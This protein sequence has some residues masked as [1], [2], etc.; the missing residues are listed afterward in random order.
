[1]PCV[2]PLPSLV[3]LAL[4]VWVS[5]GV[6]AEEPPTQAEADPASE[7]DPPN[8]TRV[9]G[10]PGF[11]PKV[12]GLPLT[13]SL[14]KTAED[15]LRLTPGVVVVQ[16]GAEGKAHQLYLRGFD[17]LHG[18]DLEVEL[19]GV[20]LNEGGNVHATGYFDLSL[21]PVALV[22][23]LTVDKGPFSLDQGLFGTAGTARYRL[24]VPLSRRGATVGYELGTTNRHRVSFALAPEAARDE[25]FLGGEFVTDSGFGERRAVPHAEV[26]ALGAD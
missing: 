8:R 17:A 5:P 15:A 1:M 26:E 14:P 23:A 11:T 9:T 2:L 3:A 6:L 12:G 20:R 24:G 25:S 21:V 13:L 16:H 19:E 18:A 10:Q 7:P 4:V 22:T